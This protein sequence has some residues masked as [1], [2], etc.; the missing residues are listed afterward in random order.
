MTIRIRIDKDRK[1]RN[2]NMRK[3][4]LRRVF[5]DNQ[6]TKGFLRGEGLELATLEL[7]WRE[8]KFRLSCI[9][10]GRYTCVPYSSGRFSNVY[11]VTD[12]PGRT[13]ILIHTGNHAGD[14]TKGYKSDVEGC[15]LVGISHCTLSGQTAVYPSI[16]AMDKL[17]GAIGKNAFELLIV[18]DAQ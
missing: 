10:A 18:V 11:E 3:L 17:R 15:I 13:K 2:K 4:T 5:S 1:Q 6:G 7:P 9:P 14:T 8:N 12:V 16:P